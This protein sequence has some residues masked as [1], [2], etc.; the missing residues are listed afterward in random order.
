MR[1][2]LMV[3]MVV[4]ICGCSANATAKNDSTPL[5]EEVIAASIPFPLVKWNNQIY[6]IS[7]DTVS[8]AFEKIGEIEHQSLND[9]AE[10]P[11]NFSTTY[12]IGTQLYSLIDV[13]TS[14][15]IAI[16]IKDDEYIKAICVQYGK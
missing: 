16:R 13:D 5:G 1:K 12:P 11:D 3:L 6:R 2:L 14:E 8:R 9:L 15:A 10:T 7:T 4:L